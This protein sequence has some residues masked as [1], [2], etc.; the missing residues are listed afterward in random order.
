MEVDVLDFRERCREVFQNGFGGAE[1]FHYP[2]SP[3]LAQ[4]KNCRIESVECEKA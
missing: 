3:F 1:V 4:S 2:E